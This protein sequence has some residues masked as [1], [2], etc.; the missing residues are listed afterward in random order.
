M[1]REQPADFARAIDEQTIAVELVLFHQQATKAPRIA[2]QSNSSEMNQFSASVA[3]D[4]DE[5]AHSS[6]R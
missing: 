1:Q 6:H 4:V 5:E 3:S 2:A